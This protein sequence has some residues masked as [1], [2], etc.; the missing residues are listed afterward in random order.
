M[1]HI[2]KL[3]VR[4]CRGCYP[5]AVVLDRIKGKASPAA[6]NLDYMIGR[7][8]V[9]FCTDP[10]ELGNLRL[11]QRAVF[12]FKY[13]TGVAH[14]LVKKKAEEFITEVIMGDDIFLTPLLRVFPEAGGI[15]T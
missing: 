12:I 5:A 13:T 15:S 10:V 2:L 9:E 4:D 3:V 8:E 1:L 7:R 14:A 11:V 6:S